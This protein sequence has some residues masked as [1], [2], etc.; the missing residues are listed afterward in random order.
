MSLTMSNMTSS[1]ICCNFLNMWKKSK[2]STMYYLNQDAKLSNLFLQASSPTTGTAPR[3]QS[4]L[5]VCPSTQDICRSS[6]LHDMSE[7][8]FEHCTPVMVLSHARKESGKKPVRQ[9]PRRRRR[10]SQR[11]EHAEEQ[12]KE[13]RND[14]RLQISSPRW[15][16]LDMESSDSSSTDESH[17]VQA[18]RQAQVKFRLSRRRRNNNKLCGSL[19]G[20]ST[21]DRMEL[22]DLG[23][24]GEKHQELTEGGSHSLNSCRGKVIRYQEC[25][26]P[27]PRGSLVEKTPPGSHSGNKGKYCQRDP[28]LLRTL[29]QKETIQKRF[30]ETDC[31]TE[32]LA[33]AEGDKCVDVAGF[34]L[35]TS[36]Q[37]SP[38]AYDD[39]SDN[40]EVCRICH[41]EGD[42]ESPLITPCRCTGTLR[43]VHQSCLHQWIKSSDTR[44]CELCKYD[45]IM[46]TKLKP[47][48]KELITSCVRASASFL[49]PILFST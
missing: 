41:C 31:N 49:V 10:V 39:G 22:V 6:I 2:I 32:I 26:H 14:F 36:T 45:F 29:R 44:C 30:L 23:S 1:H 3:S 20:S 21:P 16:E 38:G 46:E 7:D 33:A 11:Y 13:R 28:Q 25:S 15:R 40:F 37:K 47:L 48:R 34:Q 24:K 5:S 4:R 18:K 42:E 12:A 35:N 19:A 43:F 27:L 17:W 9:N 8:A